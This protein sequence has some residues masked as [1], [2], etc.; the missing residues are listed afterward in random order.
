MSPPS[1]DGRAVPTR[2]S[3]TN[4]RAA[5]RAARVGE[6]RSDT[7]YERRRTKMY[8]GGGVLALIVIILLLVWLF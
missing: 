5:F 1:L 2:G 8:I 4:V 7:R 3:P 6:P